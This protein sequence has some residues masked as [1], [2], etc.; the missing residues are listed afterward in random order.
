MK[1]SG[2]G[3]ITASQFFSPKLPTAG[4]WIWGGGTDRT[5]ADG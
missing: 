1:K 3:D 4:G 5:A 2:L